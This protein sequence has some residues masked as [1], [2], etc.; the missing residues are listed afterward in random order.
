MIN[1]NKKLK[2][3]IWYICVNYPYQLYQTKI[4]KLLFF[5]EANYHQRYSKLISGIRYFKNI[6]GSIPDTKKGLN[7]L[8]D[9]QKEKIVHK[10]DSNTFRAIR[11]FEQKYISD[12]EIDIIKQTCDKYGRLNLKELSCLSHQDELYL[13]TEK[14]NDVIDFSNSVYRIEDKGENEENECFE[15][16]LSQK[17]KSSLLEYC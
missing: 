3:M 16:K 10:T 5:S 13:M 1:S 15:L 2:E 14:M 7:V 9:L 12:E 11:E 8:E 17:V 4:W 6:H